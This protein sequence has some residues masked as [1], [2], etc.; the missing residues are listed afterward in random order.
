MR[1]LFSLENKNLFPREP[2]KNAIFSPI[3]DVWNKSGEYFSILSLMSF[4]GT[5][6]ANS[7]YSPNNDHPEVPGGRFFAI[8]IAFTEDKD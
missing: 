1:S 8:Q 4:L 6:K 7:M 5:K 2:Q 3:I